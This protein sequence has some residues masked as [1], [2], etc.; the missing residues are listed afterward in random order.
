MFCVYPLEEKCNFIRYYSFINFCTRTLSIYPFCLYLFKNTIFVRKS[1]GKV[2]F[3]WKTFGKGWKTF[4]F[5]EKGWKSGKLTKNGW[6]KKKPFWREGHDTKFVSFQKMVDK[7]KTFLKQKML[8]IF[9]QVCIFCFKMVFFFEKILFVSNSIF[10][11][12]TLFPLENLWKR[13]YPFVQTFLYIIWIFK[14]QKRETKSE[15]QI[16]MYQIYIVSLQKYIAKKEY[17][18]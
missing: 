16:K 10:V 17:K 2:G 4:L 18:K 8:R 3:P 5:F 9:C 6:Q 11:R 15:W 12:K 1:S 7:K 13:L 14:R